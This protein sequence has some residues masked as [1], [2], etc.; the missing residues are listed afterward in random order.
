[1]KYFV[2]AKYKSKYGLI[3]YC[4]KLRDGEEDNVD[5]DMNNVYLITLYY[6]GEKNIE[7]GSAYAF[8]TI[9][10]ENGLTYCF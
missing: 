10:G 9:K 4:A 8:Q 7:V 5:I 6:K 1:M 2:V 3:I